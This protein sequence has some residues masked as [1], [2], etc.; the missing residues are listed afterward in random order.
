MTWRQRSIQGSSVP[1]E[2][3]FSGVVDLVTLDRNS[4]THETISMSMS[5]KEWIGNEQ[6]ERA[7]LFIN[8]EG[9]VKC[10]LVWG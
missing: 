10:G 3:L 1:S 6:I 7:R 9:A 4:L 5:L 2:E 8:A